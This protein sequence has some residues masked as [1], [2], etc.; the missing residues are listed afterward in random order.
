M[1]YRGNHK[2][3]GR[4][5][6]S[7]GLII[8]LGRNL[9]T[10]KTSGTSIVWRNLEIR[11]ETTGRM[12]AGVSQPPASDVLFAW[13]SVDGGSGL[14]VAFATHRGEHFLAGSRITR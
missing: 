13:D 14:G 8:G 9:R 11:L 4:Q 10:S 7:L 5:P 3:V 6:Q 2:K 12:L 1:L